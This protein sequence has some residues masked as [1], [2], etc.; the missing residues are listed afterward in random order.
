MI[1]K[2]KYKRKIKVS[3]SKINYHVVETNKLFYEISIYR[4]IVYLIVILKNIFNFYLLSIK[5]IW[6]AF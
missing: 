6:N 4:F 5:K 2:V 3:W 1:K